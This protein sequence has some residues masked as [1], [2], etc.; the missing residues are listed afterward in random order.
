MS[1]NELDLTPFSEVNLSNNEQKRVAL[2]ARVSTVEQ[3]EEGYSIDEQINVLRE[4]CEREGYTIYK[5][6]VDRGISGKNIKG[7]PA[8]QQL[9]YE[10][11]QKCFDIVLVWKMNRLSRKS[12]DLLNIVD[13]LQNKNIGF[14]SYTERYETESP[15]GRLQFQMMGAIAEFER[16]NIAE[17]VKMGMI[18][19]AKEGS[20]N[21]GQ[22][23]GYDVVSVPSDNRKRKMSKLIINED[24]A[25]IVRKI[26][27]L[28]IQGNGYKSIA[29]R[30]NNEGYKTKKNKAFSINGVKTILSNPIYAGFIRYNVRRDWSEKRR[31]NINPN[32]VIVKGQHEPIIS[33][34]VWE[35]TKSIMKTRT[36]K[37][38][39]IHSGEFPLTGILK[40]PVC[41][42]GMVLGRTTNRNKDGSK[43][44]LEYYVCGAW[45]NKGTTVCRSN[46]VRTEYA[47][48]YVLQKL[49]NLASN[50]VLIKQ[51]AMR[52]NQKNEDGKLPLQ[53]EYEMLKKSLSAIQ[54]K[55]DKYLR[56][57][58]DEVISKSDLTSQL[59]NLDNEK[60][61]LEE[62]LS[63]IEEQI[64]HGGI[65]NVN[66]EVV[67]EIMQNFMTVYKKAL[68]PEQR[69]KLLHLL[70]HKITISE[71]RKI[72]SI[73]LQLNKEVAKHFTSNGGANSS[74]TDEF[75][76]PFSIFINI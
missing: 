25:I 55:K 14:R 43:R 10:A 2:Y 22:V 66:H 75:A 61:R 24:E 60:E 29:N 73:Q 59:T 39:R 33:D 47:D 48:E 63:P 12:V 3:A 23:L 34:A 11:N 36:G 21:G 16:A 40:C 35:Q 5:E 19:R 76:P 8:I 9:L 52:I 28:Y 71:D 51:I 58:V 15:T 32:P 50:D 49:A 53:K 31:N 46:G 67:K 18:A 65:P 7:R 62:R 4:W 57:Y 68:T 20:W 37:P 69:K 74:I 44:V 13:K 56:L 30:L 72:E 64:G 6:Y 70:I 27:E 45:K 17:N 42:S 54:S 38:N 41:G 26:F 1:I